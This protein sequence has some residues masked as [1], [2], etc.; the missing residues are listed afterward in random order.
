MI[1]HARN[2]L[3]NIEPNP[4]YSATRLF[5]EIIDPNYLVKPLP[6]YLETIRRA[7]FGEAPDR[8][9]LNYRGRELLALLVNT[10]LQSFITALDPR[11]TYDLSDDS[12]VLQP[13]FQLTATQLSGAENALGLAYNPWTSASGRLAYS[14]YVSYDG[15]TANLVLHSAYTQAAYTPSFSAG[16][17]PP[18][19]LPGTKSAYITLADIP[20]TWRLSYVAKPA[21]DL[22]EVLADIDSLGNTAVLE[23]FGVG[24]PRAETEPFKTFFNLWRY[25]Y[26][27]PMRLGGILLALIYRTNE[28]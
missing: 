10:E 14:W 19:L 20:A 28:L 17:S 6:S 12:Q 2:L 13:Y 26:A 27:L 22:G 15:T 23:L 7:L 8:T 21:K 1:N 3:L 5:D 16:L 24:T 25:H 4:S 18:L 11:I 9:M